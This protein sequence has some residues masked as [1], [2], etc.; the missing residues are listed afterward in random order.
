MKTIRV[1]KHSTS[2]F[3][4]RKAIK[5]LSSL[6]LEKWEFQFLSQ[7]CDPKLA[8][9][10]ARSFCD[11]NLIRKPRHFGSKFRDKCDIVADIKM[12]LEG[13]KD[14]RC[15]KFILETTSAFENIKDVDHE[16]S[17]NEFH[18]ENDHIL[19]SLDHF[20]HLTTHP[21]MSNR[22]AAADGLDIL[23]DIYKNFHDS[24]DIK[25]ILAKIVTNMTSA[26]EPMVDFF[27]KSGWINMLASWQHDEDLR[28][29]VF[30][31]TSLNNL[32]KFDTAGFIYQPK[33]Y[34][35]YPRGRINEKP[36]LDLIFVH[37]ILGGIWVTWRVQRSADMCQDEKAPSKPGDSLTN[38]FFQE[39]A[40][41]CDEKIVQMEPGPASKILT[42]TE[43]TTK[44][45]LTALHEMAE[46][47]LSMED[48]STKMNF[49]IVVASSK[50]FPQ[51]LQLSHKIL[52]H[53]VRKM[54]DQK[55]SYCWPIDWLPQKF[56]QIRILGL[57]FESAL[58][59]WV[60]KVCP[61]EQDNLKL[62]FRSTDYL[63]RLSSAGIGDGRPVVWVCHSMGGLI[64][65]H[66]INQSLESKDPQIRKI[67]ESTAGIV[68]L[69]TPHRGS[70]IAKYSQQT[71]LL[72]PTIEVKDMEENSKELLK[73]HDKFLENIVKLRQPVEIVSIAEG[74][75]MKV[76]QNIKMIV[77]P[78]Q[79]AFLG[80]GD[81]YVSNENHLNLSK[82]ISQNS[83]IY[84]TVVNI[85]EKLLAQQRDSTKQ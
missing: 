18:H 52:R 42:I 10:L 67:G 83:F 36:A 50:M 85:L 76:F 54:N 41:F 1:A 34:P 77:V 57:Q 30:A 53:I 63:Q 48:V 28:I 33:L 43:E 64:V 31:S 71:A 44:R 55:Y 8:V 26:D 23:L 70:S 51:Q 17:L 62:K 74:S 38:S 47:K 2:S 37:G 39:E 21:D 32:D 56:P 65:K 12:M 45:V 20:V 72:W 3:V 69:G 4:R 84:L 49:K 66:I 5:N 59:Y 40:I 61:C 60:K 24:I 13:M 11:P 16:T 81:F 75:P 19:E 25:L 46:E 29:Q 6:D 80:Y 7:Y 82:P 15:V 22:I 14:N 68:F 78:M 73:L 79:S 9:S 27:F 35:L 58:S